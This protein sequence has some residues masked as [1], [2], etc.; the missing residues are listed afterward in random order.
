MDTFIVVLRR[1][2]SNIPSMILQL[3]FHG[4]TFQVKTH[5]FNGNV[6]QEI[7]LLA[8]AD[9]LTLIIVEIPCNKRCI[10]DE[11]HIDLYGFLYKKPAG[12]VV[13]IINFAQKT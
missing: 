10:K 6:F 4:S 1:S 13:S 9:L 3:F 12:G 5:A 2:N 8:H 11:I 7:H